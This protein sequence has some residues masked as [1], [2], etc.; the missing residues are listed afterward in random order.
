MSGVRGFIHPT[1]CII[2]F[3]PHNNGPLTGSI[4]RLHILFPHPHPQIYKKIKKSK[5]NTTMVTNT[6]NPVSTNLKIKKHK[7]GKKNSQHWS[8]TLQILF[9]QI[10]KIKNTTMVKKHNNGHKHYT[11]KK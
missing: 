1:K 10:T 11:S 6:T 8:Q 4:I 5:K 3:F 2:V 9:P 7:N